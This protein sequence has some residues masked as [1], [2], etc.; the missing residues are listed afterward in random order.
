MK[1]PNSRLTAVALT[2]AVFVI[3]TASSVQAVDLIG[4]GVNPA[5]N[6]GDFSLPGNFG[7]I[8]GGILT[9]DVTAQIGTGPWNGTA[10]GVLGLLIRPTISINGVPNPPDGLNAT[11][12]GLAAVNVAGLVQNGGSV[13]ETVPGNPGGS[14]PPL[15]IQY[16]LTGTFSTTDT[17]TLALL[18]NSGFGF[19]ITTGGTQGVNPTPGTDV[20]NSNTGMGGPLVTINI[21]TANT[22]NFSLIYNSPVLLNTVGVRL[23]SGEN[24]TLT[25]TAV[26]SNVTFD[27]VFLKATAIPE[28]STWAFVLGGAGALLMLARRKRGAAIS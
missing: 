25:T 13:F 28:P 26:L 19:A 10:R 22:G 11:I 7:T 23:F 6:N 15:N 16:C 1:T 8:G 5:F 24:P 18:G 12:S 4:G 21:L 9:T 17:L 27:N 2:L 20:A 14:L 3:G